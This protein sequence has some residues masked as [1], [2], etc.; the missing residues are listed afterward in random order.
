MALRLKRFYSLKYLPM[1]VILTFAF[2]GVGFSPAR[3]DTPPPLKGA[4]AAPSDAC[5]DAGFHQPGI[6]GT[7]YAMVQDSSGNIYVGGEIVTA[8]G[9]PVN[10]LAMWD[11][12]TWRDVGSGITITAGTARV[13]ALAVDSANNLIVGGF[14]THAGGTAANNLAV[15][16]GAFWQEVG[17]GV[18]GSV[19]AIKVVSGSVNVGGGMYVGGLFSQVGTVEAHNIAYRDFSTGWQARGSGVDDAVRAIELGSTGDSFFVGGDFFNA[20]GIPAVKIAR[21]NGASWEAVKGGLTQGGY[22]NALLAIGSDL[23]VGGSFPQVGEVGSPLDAHNIARWDGSNWQALSNGTGGEVLAIVPRAAGEIILGG[24]FSSAGSPAVPAE[25][26][27]RWNGSA[28]SALGPGVGT[29]G[30]EAVNALILDGTDVIAGGRFGLSSDRVVNHLARWDGAAWSAMD[31]GLGVNNVIDVL[32]SDTNAVFVSGAINQF[33]SLQALG[34]AKLTGATWSGEGSP[35]ASF[36][37]A[38]VKTSLTELIAGGAFTAIGGASANY[39]ARWNGAAWS[40]LAGG[41][42][43]YVNALAHRDGK[44]YVGGEFT[45]VGGGLSGGNPASRIAM[46]DGTWHTLGEGLNGTVYAL[47]LDNAGNLYA[48]GEFTYAGSLYVNHIALWDGSQWHALGGGL[49]GSNYVLALTFDGDGRLYAGGY[50]SQAGNKQVNG[51]AMWNGLEWSGL[52]G[53]MDD[54]VGALAVDG[55]GYLYAGGDF[56]FAGPD[57]AAHI[58][59]WNGFNWSPLGSGTDS[60]VRTLAVAGTR[61]MVGGVFKRAGGIPSSYLG[62]YTFPPLE[63]APAPTLADLFPAGTPAGGPGF[64]LTVNGT[65]FSSRSVVYW[66]GSPLITTYLSGSQLRAFVPADKIGIPG[67]ATILVSTPAPTGGGSS[68]ARA[69]EIL[70]GYRVFLPGVI[71]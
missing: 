1:V 40:E 68:L 22:V 7:V 54:G 51:V 27:V 46:W 10:N 63:L 41:T 20:G 6:T 34:L 36:I 45:T 3:A 65:N 57:Q 19:L 37:R 48:A 29:E 52:G 53:G 14:F 15:W 16:N 13:S 42:N 33:G 44:L 28:W 66:N 35:A 39:L 4:C 23:Y 12:T 38:L 2:F 21:F 25:N 11:G 71:R 62:A 18:N 47:A 69:F 59:R 56:L 30:F 17:D 60:N 50:F 58:A 64:W 70:D 55:N 67:I 32:L 49:S 8:G 9:V 61:L 5:W 24:D 26:V 43:G 31:G